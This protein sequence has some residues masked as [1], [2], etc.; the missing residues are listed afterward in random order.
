MLWGAMIT[1]IM[2][3]KEMW[4]LIMVVSMINRITLKICIRLRM[5]TYKRFETTFVCS[6]SH[7]Q[8]YWKKCL[9]SLKV[10]MAWLSE[11]R[12]NQTPVT[13]NDIIKSYCLYS[14]PCP[15][16]IKR[17]LFLVLHQLWSLAMCCSAIFAS[18]NKCIAALS[19]SLLFLGS[20][21]IP[22]FGAC[23]RLGGNLIHQEHSNKMIWRDEFKSKLIPFI[24]VSTVG[25]LFL[26]TKWSKDEKQ[27][28]W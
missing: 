24:D 27:R 16:Q 4:V 14:Y 20:F 13:I 12:R 7:H 22:F 8:I 15:E 9:I 1:C 11:H 21:S 6:L 28:Q 23:I 3:G 5:F 19:Q 10:L 17:H 18:M 2:K 25:P 26:L